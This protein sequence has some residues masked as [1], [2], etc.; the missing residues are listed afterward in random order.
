MLT[1][2]EDI[3]VYVFFRLKLR[4]KSNLIWLQIKNEYW[5]MTLV[6][7]YTYD[8][9]EYFTNFI[10]FILIIVYIIYQT[11]IICDDTYILCMD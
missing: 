1:A 9:R 2:E 4:Q 5:N 11:A 7:N 10:L 6:I 3:S 8:I